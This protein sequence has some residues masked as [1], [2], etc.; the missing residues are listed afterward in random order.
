MYFPG[1]DFSGEK[2]ATSFWFP[3]F[4]WRGAGALARVRCVSISFRSF[5]HVLDLRR[6]RGIN[7]V[8]TV[9]VR[10]TTAQLRLNFKSR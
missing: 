1:A 10:L 4:I 8:T 5:I 6:N 3:V 2:L 9:A 7:V